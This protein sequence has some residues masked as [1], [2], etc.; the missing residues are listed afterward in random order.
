MHKRRIVHRDLKLENV[1]LDQPYKQSDEVHQ[2]S[3]GHRV[4][5]RERE[6]ERETERERDKRLRALCPPR[7]HTP[8]YVGG[9]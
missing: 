5:E 1:L 8:G 4:R 9:M 3:I 2:V 7:A 6:R